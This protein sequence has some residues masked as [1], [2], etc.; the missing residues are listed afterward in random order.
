MS[1]LKRLFG[2]GASSGGVGPTVTDREEYK[3]HLIEA[4]PEKE[5]GQ[6]RLRAKLSKEIDGET[7]VH[8]LI[9]A[10][11]LASPEEATTHAL[12]KG[13]QVID[14]MGDRLYG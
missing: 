4:M 1:F 7:K 8:Q 14:E 12:A 2:G 11:L 10:D 13:R 3:G 5:G 6:Y 9:R